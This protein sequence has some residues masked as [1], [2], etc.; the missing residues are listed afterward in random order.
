M[1]LIN[2]K[3]KN[4][5]Y[6]SVNF[7]ESLYKWWVKVEGLTYTETRHLTERVGEQAERQSD[8]MAEFSLPTWV[9]L[10]ALE[11]LGYK[12]NTGCPPQKKIGFRKVAQFSCS[13][14]GV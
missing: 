6:E 9:L 8:M 11:G 1:E 7:R 12:V 13:P 3:T 10:N 2:A 14:R 5:V 4:Y